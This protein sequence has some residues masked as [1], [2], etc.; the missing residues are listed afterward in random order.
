MFGYVRIRKSELRIR[1]YEYY[2]AAY[3]GLCRQMGKCTGQ[4]SR[5]TLSYDVAFL[6]HVRML[7]CGTVPVFKRRRCLVHPLKK[8]PMMEENDQ[9]SYCADVSALLG[10]EKCRDDVAD[11][12]FGGSLKA[13]LRCLFLSNAYRRAR[14][15]LPELAEAL[16]GHLAALS[17]LERERPA[18]VDAPAAIFGALVAD[19]TAYGLSGPQERVART[20]GDKVGRFIYIID[21][22][23]DL[24]KDAKRGNFN[25]VLALFGEKPTNEERESI[26][27]ALIACLS[28]L[29]A[30]LDLIEEHPRQEIKAV[31]ENIL[32]FGMPDTV[33]R[34]LCGKADREEDIPGEQ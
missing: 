15:R 14:N 13:R 1:E 23:D 17:R 30:A 9:L 28:D 34:V 21:A 25:P 20:I 19:M 22:I 10:Y 18:S 31:V 11:E 3:C 6:V 32:Y 2:R 27:V 7:L 16:R 12:G 24:E 33:R 5:L 8:R 26:R 4:C 29:E